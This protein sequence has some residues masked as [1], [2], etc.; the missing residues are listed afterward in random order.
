MPLFS[1]PDAFQAGAIEKF[2]EG[3]W[4]YMSWNVG[5]IYLY[6]LALCF[7]PRLSQFLF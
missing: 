2:K 5:N 7:F 6:Q 1:K 3:V 4:G